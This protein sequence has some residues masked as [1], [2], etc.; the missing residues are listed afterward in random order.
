MTIHTINSSSVETV[1]ALHSSASSRSQWKDLE[2]VL[3][4][5]YSFS[6][7]NLPGYGNS[8]IIADSSATGVASIAGPVI[9]EI[10]KA[11][12]PVHLIGHSQGGGVAIKI[13]LMRPDLVRSLTLYEPATFHF[14]KNGSTIDRAAFS[15]ICQVSGILSAASASGRPDIGMMQFI[16]YWNGAGT[17]KNLPAEQ[18]QKFAD[19]AIVVM[20]DFARGFEET[21]TLEDLA[22]ITIPT[23]M[24]IGLK[25][26]NVAQHAASRIANA[27]PGTTTAMLGELGHMAPVF[28]AQKINRLIRQHILE[29]ENSEIFDTFHYAYA[30]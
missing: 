18:R 26:T 25:S 24:M 14:L 8:S 22:E 20:S 15:E 16:D 1:F 9:R 3:G 29:V 2:K 13:A 6:A 17:W 5:D 27:I 23:M 11:K 28:Q 21:W 7:P 4:S 19:Q 12:L 30:A 10:E